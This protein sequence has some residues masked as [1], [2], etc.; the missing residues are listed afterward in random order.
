MRIMLILTVL[1]VTALGWAL[2]VGQIYDG[3]RYLS[4]Y[5]QAYGEERFAASFLVSF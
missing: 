5:Y 2:Y 1:A 4:H 3:S